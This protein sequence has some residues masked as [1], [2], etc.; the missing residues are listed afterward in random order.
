MPRFLDAINDF[1]ICVFSDTSNMLSLCIFELFYAL[2]FA[3]SNILSFDIFCAI[4]LSTFT[5]SNVDSSFFALITKA[6]N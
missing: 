1:G 4:S 5:A 6:K 3:T 2:E